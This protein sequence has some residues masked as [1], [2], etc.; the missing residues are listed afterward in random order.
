MATNTRARELVAE[1]RDVISFAAGEPD[2]PTPEHIVAAAT[3]AARDPVHH[4]Y[5]AAAGHPELREAVAE[6]TRRHSEVEVGAAEVAITNGAKQAV[7]NTFAAILDPGDEVLLPAPYWVTY[8]ASVKLAGGNPVLVKTTPATSFKVTV[9]DLEA[10]VTERT[11][12]LVLVSPSNPT[13][14][15]YREE[16]L[17]T[18]GEWAISNRVWVVADEIYQRLVYPTGIAP[19]IA[20]A[21]PGLETWILINGVAKSYAMTGW[22]VGWMVGPRDVV[23][24]GVR[25]QSHATSNVNNIAQAAALAAVTGPQETV[26]QMRAA[27]DRRRKLMFDLVSG[28][29]G[30]SCIEPEGAFYV[31]PDVT[32]LLGSRFADAVELSEAILEDAGAAVIPGDSFGAPGFIRLSYATGDEDIKT[33]L[34]RIAGM[35]GS[36]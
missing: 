9:E 18:I 2:F 26:E 15:F 30:I 6:Y 33:G 35:F 13:G 22:R 5:T 28:I 12:A 11:R 17:K 10:A 31:F 29:E 32:G 1:G 7:F 16:E 25:L 27:F 4:H 20:A 14:A 34:G 3:R 23:D 36:L 24:A 21:S 8:P 19:S